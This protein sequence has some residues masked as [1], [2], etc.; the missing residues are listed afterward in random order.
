[1]FF[2]DVPSQKWLKPR[3][4]SGLDWLMCAKFAR[5][6]PTPASVAQVVALLEEERLAAL[7]R[8]ALLILLPLPA[9]EGLRLRIESL[10]LRIGGSRLKV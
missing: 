8:G 4:R 6:R 9:L 1:M 10:R 2:K 7:L 5:Q 3:P